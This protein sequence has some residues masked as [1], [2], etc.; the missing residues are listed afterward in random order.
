MKIALYYSM[1][2]SDEKWDRK[3]RMTLKIVR[4]RQK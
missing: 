4:F 1:R 3:N 2:N